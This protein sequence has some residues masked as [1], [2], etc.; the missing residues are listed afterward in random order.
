MFIMALMEVVG[1]GSI[2]PFLT[3]LSDPEIIETDYKFKKFN[4]LNFESR[5]SFLLFLGFFALLMLL[6]SVLV[7]S[8]TSYAKFRFQTSD[9][10]VLVKDF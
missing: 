4:S 10:I 9:G 6:L 1:V 3:V 8:I 5:H 7:R 2:M